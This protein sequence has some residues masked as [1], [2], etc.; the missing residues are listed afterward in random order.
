MT[1]EWGDDDDIARGASVRA[2]GCFRFRA[3][4][5][6]SERPCVT[7]LVWLSALGSHQL[8]E[9]L[10]AD[11]GK[12]PVLQGADECVPAQILVQV[13]GGRETDKGWRRG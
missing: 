5:P 3:C 13:P 8:R 2:G 4:S 1:S 6:K 10:L 11:R 7:A 9:L 12:P